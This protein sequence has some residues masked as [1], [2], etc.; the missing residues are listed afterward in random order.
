MRLLWKNRYYLQITVLVILGSL[1]SFGCES[2]AEIKEKEFETK[3]PPKQE[4]I[5]PLVDVRVISSDNKTE[6]EA[7]FYHDISEILNGQE[8]KGFGKNIIKV[9][10]PKLGDIELKE[11]ENQRGWTVYST[12]VSNETKEYELTFSPSKNLESAHKIKLEPIIILEK[13]LRFKHG[14]SYELKLSREPAAG[15]LPAVVEIKNQ[16][17]K[18]LPTTVRYV[19]GSLKLDDASLNPFRKGKTDLYV[20][21]ETI[22]HTRESNKSI[23]NLNYVIRREIEIVE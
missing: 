12:E 19:N 1:I 22:P 16:S 4:S 5:R 17:D 7:I 3:G 10:N 20:R 21:F 2:A 23:M 8:I 13:D 9:N 15:E 14:K 11:S 18:F 6:F